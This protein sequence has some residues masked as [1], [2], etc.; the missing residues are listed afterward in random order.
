MAFQE[1][2]PQVTQGIG[3]KI[4]ILRV[5]LVLSIVALPV[6]AMAV[7][8]AFRVL[9]LHGLVVGASLAAYVPLLFSKK[10]SVAIDSSFQVKFQNRPMVNRQLLHAS[11]LSIGVF[12]FQAFLWAM[13]L[14]DKL[15]R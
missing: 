5:L 10:P 3:W 2:T 4:P 11:L 8:I 9:P 12:T 1:Y 6:A 7:S 15:Q 13:A 14:G